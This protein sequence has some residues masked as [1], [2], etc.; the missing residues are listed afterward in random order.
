MAE[1]AELVAL[2]PL[3]DVLSLDV[4]SRL[5][6]LDKLRLA[7][8][9]PGWRAAL[10]S[11]AVWSRVDLSTRTTPSLPHVTAAF[12]AAVCARA[13]R[14]LTSLDLSGRLEEAGGP[15]S[16]EG[17]CD[18]L[19]SGGCDRLSLLRAFCAD[20]DDLP[21]LPEGEVASL[22]S[23]L[24][25]RA[26]LEADVGC[27]SAT[28]GPLLRGKHPFA[29]L[30]LRR[31]FVDGGVAEADAAAPAAAFSPA[32]FVS[33]MEAHPSLCQLVLDSVPGLRPPTGLGAL[34]GATLGDVPAISTL[35]LV[36]SRLCPAS[37]PQ[38]TRLITAAPHLTRLDVINVDDALLNEHNSLPFAAALAANSRLTSLT[39]LQVC[40]WDEPG[41]GLPVL[42]AL[43]AHPSITRL[44][45]RRN[46][47]TAATCTAIGAA[48]GSIL[49]ADT[50][51]SLDVSWCSLRDGGLRGLAAPLPRLASLRALRCFGNGCSPAFA[52][53]LRALVEANASLSAL[54]ADDGP[55][56]ELP[57]LVAAEA[58]VQHRTAAAA[59]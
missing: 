28:A 53:E 31:L 42:T 40:L 32:A 30:R 16:C 45:L 8:V 23:R 15:L 3:P 46:H 26:V 17:V 20:E 24:P 12:L 18:A 44:D 57:D 9:S 19:A 10:R 25:A 35:S 14:A 48:L 4:F 11:P 1:R 5:S 49:A 34:V 21:T 22:A 56:Q 36:H 27:T 55:G 52:P 59:V 54:A 2:P 43:T 13:G 7:A 51:R 33:D 6:V 37:T 39:L 41:L 58:G 38:L 47:A 29:A 50:L